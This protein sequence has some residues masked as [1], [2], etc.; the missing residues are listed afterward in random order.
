MRRIGSPGSMFD[1]GRG[2]G[3]GVAALCGRFWVCLGFHGG[4]AVPFAASL[5]RRRARR[6]RVEVEHRRG[7][8]GET[9]AHLAPLTILGRAFEITVAMVTIPDMPF[10]V[11]L[12]TAAWAL[13]YERPSRP[14]VFT[15]GWWRCRRRWR[16]WRWRL[17]RDGLVVDDRR[18]H[19]PVSTDEV[20]VGHMSRPVR[21]EP[22]GHGAAH[23]SLQGWDEQFAFAY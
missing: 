2:R 17:R 15:L 19:R 14:G 11:M 8:L 9:F 13:T 5:R 22:R 4:S 6:G 3:S 23:W 12:V 7:D 18:A 20:V 21:L 1:H 16:R 10:G